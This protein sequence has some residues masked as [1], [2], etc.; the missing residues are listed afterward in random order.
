MSTTDL[1]GVLQSAALAILR[2]DTAVAALA[3]EFRAWQDNESPRSN[4]A[5]I[6]QCHNMTPEPLAPTGLPCGYYKSTLLCMAAGI[7]DLQGGGATDNLF[8]AVRAAFFAITPAA[9]NAQ[10]A[11]AVVDGI[12][13]GAVAD[14]YEANFAQN[15]FEATVYYHLAA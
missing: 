11:A 6:A 12:I 4:L 10:Q 3:P 14:T 7:I 1:N 5:V 15:T 2:A 13:F 9:L 8:D